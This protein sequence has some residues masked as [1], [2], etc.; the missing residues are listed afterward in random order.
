[1]AWWVTL[2]VCVFAPATSGAATPHVRAQSVTARAAAAQVVWV[3]PVKGS[4]KGR[5]TR[6]APFRTLD[7]AWHRSRDGATIHI[8]PGRVRVGATYYEQ[9]KR[10]RI[11]GSGM[12]RTVV[13]P[14]NIFGVRDMTIASLT[15]E[16]DVHCEQCV[17]FTL[18]GVRVRGRGQVQE[19]VKVNQSSRVR[20][21]RSDISGATDNSIDFVGVQDAWI[22]G[23]HVHH[24][25]DWCAYAKGGSA[26]IRVWNNTIDH[27]GTGGFTAG[28]GTGLQFMVAPWT[29]YEAYDVR[30]WNNL[31]ADIEGAG[32]G[33]NG[34]YDVLF[35]RNTL[36]RVGS[37][38][39]AL[40]VVF[41]L[42]SCDGQPGDEGRERC[43]SLLAAGA[44]GTTRVDDG[45]NA[46]RIPNK[47]VWFYDN[48][49]VK[50]AGSETTSVADPYD[51]ESQ[52]GS[53]V[54]RPALADEDLRLV[55][56]IVS[57]DSP[58]S[59]AAT[60]IPPFTWDE[61]GVPAPG[62]LDNATLTGMPASAG[63]TRVAR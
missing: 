54:P 17:G 4:D 21:L 2:A 52:D 28:Q 7:V 37:R 27:C 45:T 47:H 49:V 24:A 29:R 16:G 51:G 40:E 15:V 60:P 58:G 43:G 35:A 23:S 62:S 48:V 34:G 10:V 56:T 31:I 19:G 25:E 13:P 5:G 12:L 11:V 20:I 8:L 44:W 30:V 32:L 61:T 50:A 36:L 53:G 39:H 46:V 18:D 41:G 3:D 59:G 38:S 42:R 63:S 1:M 55:N 14:F 57:T 9:R 6:K 22:T 33:V 26:Y